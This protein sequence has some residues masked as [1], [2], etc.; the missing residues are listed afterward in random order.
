[1]QGEEGRGFQP[2]LDALNVLGRTRWRINTRVYDIMNRV[3]QDG[4]G[5]AGIPQ[6]R[7]LQ[8]DSAFAMRSTGLQLLCNRAQ[9]KDLA[10][11]HP[12]A[13]TPHLP[14][15]TLTRARAARRPRLPGVV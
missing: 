15:H 14:T 12:R 7:D 9:S 4:G 13:R 10:R 6:T 11:A 8:M 2:V 3:W 1:M 5:V